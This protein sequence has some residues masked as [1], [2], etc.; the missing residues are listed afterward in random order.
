MK[1][2]KKNPE[3]KNPV[4]PVANDE[5]TKKRKGMEEMDKDPSTNPEEDNDKRRKKEDPEGPTA[6]KKSL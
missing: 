3:R 6:D 1:Q 4:T 2:N 5:D